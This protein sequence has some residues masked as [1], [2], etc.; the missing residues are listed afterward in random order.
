VETKVK[1]LI[2][3]INMAAK[4]DI[5]GDKIITKPNSTGYRNNFDAIDW[6]ATRK[7]DEK[8]T[9]ESKK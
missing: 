7:K 6:S 3:G 4:N 1:T 9:A 8:P 2:Q 5:T